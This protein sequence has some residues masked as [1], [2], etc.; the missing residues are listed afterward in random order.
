MG[1]NGAVVAEFLRATADSD[2]DAAVDLVTEDFVY[3]IIDFDT[4]RGREGLRAF[5][6]DQASIMAVHR[7]VGRCIEAGDDV[8]VERLDTLVFSVG[9]VDLPCAGFFTCRDG[10]IAYWADYQD[11]REVAR[12][13][14]H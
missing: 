4:Y 13:L 14:G 3:E 1:A 6:Y 10:R 9:P 8:A 12:T 7:E 11:L 5:L 2:A